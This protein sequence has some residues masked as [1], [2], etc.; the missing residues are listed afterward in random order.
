MCVYIAMAKNST[1][2]RPNTLSSIYSV[3]R[4]HASVTVSLIAFKLNSQTTVYNYHL[5]HFPNTNTDIGNRV[6]TYL[7]IVPRLTAN[8]TSGQFSF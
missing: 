1:S 4:S 8:M 7:D 2:F 3:A 6:I 5:Y